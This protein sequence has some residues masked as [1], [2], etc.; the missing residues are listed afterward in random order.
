MTGATL[1]PRRRLLLPEMEGLTARWY[2]R[3]RGTPSQLALYRRQAEQ[4]TSGLP[5]G[6]AVLEVAPGPGYLAVEIARRAK[7]EVTGLDVSRTMVEIAQAHAA[8]AGVE[9]DLRHGD[10]ASMPFPEG[11]FDLVVCQ[12]AFKNFRQPVRALSEMHRVL[13]GGGQAVIHDM[14]KEATPPDIEREVAAQG[15]TAVNAF[16]T[17]KILAGLRGRAYSRP[18]FERLV[19]ES[20]FR[21]AEF[22]TA[23]VG[24]EVRLRKEQ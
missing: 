23:G 5:A 21:R 2:S 15:L 6:A 24:V 19:A 12:A 8:E 20:R 13:K 1:R 11:S 22:A 7:F 4:L 16:L 9:V 18:A 3:Q 14:R 17:R 10:A